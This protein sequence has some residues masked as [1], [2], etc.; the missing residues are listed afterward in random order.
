MDWLEAH[1]QAEAEAREEAAARR[2][3]QRAPMA[4]ARGKDRMTLKRNRT[5]QIDV[6]RG[7]RDRWR[8]RAL[9][10]ERRAA[11]AE[12]EKR[13]AERELRELKASREGRM[14]RPGSNCPGGDVRVADGDRGPDDRPERKR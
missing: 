14:T 10:A 1:M 12:I 7:S 5:P 4:D 8:D 3:G 6:V 9:N 11:D 13:I 2:P